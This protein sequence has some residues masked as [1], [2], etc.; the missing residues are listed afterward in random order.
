MPGPGPS[1]RPEV[2]LG[3]GD[4]LGQA[5]MPQE[6]HPASPFGAGWTWALRGEGAPHLPLP[7]VGKAVGHQ[8]CRNPLPCGQAAPL[9]TRRGT[10]DVAG[11]GTAGSCSTVCREMGKAPSTG[12]LVALVPCRP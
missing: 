5:P 4:Q 3:Q 12:A 2:P 1:L 10:R 7:A 11:Y 6:S 8:G 9:R